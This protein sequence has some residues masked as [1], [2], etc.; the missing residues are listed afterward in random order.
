MLVLSDTQVAGKCKAIT[1]DEVQAKQQQQINKSR[2]KEIIWN[3]A[4][5]RLTFNLI[6][7]SSR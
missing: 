2:K 7:E 6:C 3:A 5:F 1:I 4:C